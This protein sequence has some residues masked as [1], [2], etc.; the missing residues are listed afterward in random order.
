MTSRAAFIILLLTAV[1]VVDGGCSDRKKGKPKPKRMEGI[2]EKIDLQNNYV[3]MRVSDGQGGER[4]LEGT[5]RED[6]EVE[7]NGRLAKLDQVRVGDKVE[8]FGYREKGDE[9]QKLVAMK[10]VVTR[11]EGSDWKNSGK[12]PEKPAEAQQSPATQKQPAAPATAPAV[13]SDEGKAGS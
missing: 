12:P 5:F 7:I 6:T 2:A 13:K 3:S 8:V 1:V 4:I 9:D 11:P 10:V